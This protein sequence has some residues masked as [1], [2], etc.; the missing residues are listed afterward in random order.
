MVLPDDPDAAERMF[1]VQL[2]KNIDT[3][4]GSPDEIEEPV[5]THTVVFAP[6][7]DDTADRLRSRRM[8]TVA[9]ITIVITAAVC[10]AA[11]VWI[12]GNIFYK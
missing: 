8:P 4:A 6:E 7:P 5:R 2:L 12:V 11:A 10:I 1:G 9:I 3:G